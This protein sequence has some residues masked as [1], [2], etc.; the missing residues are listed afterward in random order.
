M[1][2]NHPIGV[3]DSGV[4]GLTVVSEIIKQ[5]PNENIVYFGDTARVPYGEKTP[6][7]INAFVREIINF[8]L[9]FKVKAV[10]MACN[11]S[12]A[13]A[14]PTVKNEYDIPMFEMINPAIEEVKNA[15]KNKRVGVIANY[16]TINSNVFKDKIENI[17]DGYKAFQ[18]ACPLLV[19]LVERGETDTSYAEK[20]LHTYLDPMISEDIDTLILGC[21]HYPHLLPPIIRITGIDVNVLDPAEKVVNKAKDYFTRN[22]LLKDDSRR[23]HKYFV[24]GS[25]S[26]FERTARVLFAGEDYSNVEQVQP[27][28][29]QAAGRKINV[30]L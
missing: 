30:F 13:L 12:S 17:G 2:K 19:P 10:I 5:L 24:S 27:E 25:P 1:I 4:G 14:Y 28:K 26:H 16:V 20:V 15:S 29:L 8:L 18:Q 23:M 22:D 6:Q 9:K 11:T 7:Q 21:T 3:F